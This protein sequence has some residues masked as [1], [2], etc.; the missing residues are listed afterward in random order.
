M[1]QM[2]KKYEDEAD[3]SRLW[4]MLRQ[5]LISKNE[6]KTFGAVV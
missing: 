1:Q 6:L 3:L 5:T 2:L 4:Q